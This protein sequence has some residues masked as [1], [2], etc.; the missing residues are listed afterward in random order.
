MIQSN[1]ASFVWTI[2]TDKVTCQLMVDVYRKDSVLNI[3][4]NIKSVWNMQLNENRIIYIYPLF[5]DF[6]S[7]TYIFL[8][9]LP[10]GWISTE[11]LGLPVTIIWDNYINKK[12]MQW[13]YH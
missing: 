9:S 2:T 3:K 5:C 7:F 10:F 11:G 13:I 6:Y 4:N 1:P 8:P 12:K